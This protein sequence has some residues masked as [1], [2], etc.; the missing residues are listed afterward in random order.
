MT[1]PNSIILPC[2]NRAF[3]DFDSGMGYRCNSCYAMHGSIGQPTHCQ[4]E[5][6]KWKALEALG[7]LGWDYLRGGQKRAKEC[8]TSKF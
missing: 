3:W 8:Q 7:G 6:A 2:G 5:T 4:N 1:Q